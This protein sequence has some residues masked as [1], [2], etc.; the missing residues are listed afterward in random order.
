M[1]T[2]AFFKALLFLAAGSVI[3]ALGGDQDIRRMGGLKGHI[4]ITFMTFLIGVLAISG[5]PPFSGFFS[6]DEILAQAFAYSPVV[7]SLVLLASLLTVGYM[8]RLLFLT[9]YGSPRAAESVISHVHESPLRMTIPLVLLAVLSFA[10]GFINIPTA[11]S[12][13][14]ALHEYLSPLLHSVGPEHHVAHSTEYLLMAVVFVLTLII[15]GVTYNRYVRTSHV[16]IT[17]TTTSG[18]RKLLSHKYYVDEL[19]DIVIV[20][21][22]LW[23][24]HFFDTVIERQALDRIVNS[25]GSL[26]TSSSEVMRRL[27]TGSIGFYIFIMVISIIAILTFTTVRVMAKW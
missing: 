7:W 17:E 21:P 27:Q 13:S 5:I 19:Y 25:V 12:G 9:F 14:A 16:P 2:H 26:V 3:H 18:V 11:L 15:I 20:R 6:K 24:S 23:L 4:P 1:V 8:F 22:L 10:G